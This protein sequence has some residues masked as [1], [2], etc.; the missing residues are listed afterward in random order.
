MPFDISPPDRPGHDLVLVPKEAYPWV[1]PN[2][3]RKGL[4][5]R[6]LEWREKTGRY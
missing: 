2:F 5:S 1:V 4:H 3:P 6:G